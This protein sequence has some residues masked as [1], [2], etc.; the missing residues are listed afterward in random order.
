[1]IIFEPKEQIAEYVLQM[2]GS[3]NTP[4]DLFRYTALAILK[5]GIIQAGIVFER[6]TGESIEM[7]IAAN[8]S[9]RWMTKTFLHLWFHYPFIQLGVNR[10]TAN[11]AS[12]N[13]SALNLAE[14]LGFKKEGVIREAMGGDDLIAYGMLKNECRFI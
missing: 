1:L 6:F 10:I 11:I 14:R 12:K 2:I 13:K 4:D 7:H 3:F 5:N 8:P 9:K